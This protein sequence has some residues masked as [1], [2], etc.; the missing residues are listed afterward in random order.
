MPFSFKISSLFALN[1]WELFT[2]LMVLVSP[3]AVWILVP[4]TV[5]VL[6]V[7][8]VVVVVALR[9]RR[10]VRRVGVLRWGKVARVTNADEI[11]RG[12][13]FSG[14]TYQN[15]RLRQATGW[16]TTTRWYSGPG[17][18]ST[19]NYS[20]DDSDGTLTLRGLP[21][22]NGVILADPRKPNRAYCVSSFPFSVKPDANGEYVDHGL[23]PWAWLGIGLTVTVYAA[24]IA[25][26]WYAVDGLWLDLPG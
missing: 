15:I 17:S 16:D 18:K 26:A 8:L 9:A 2:I 22:A 3:I 6:F 10:Y 19:I 1:V 14:T 13:Y 20:V 5:P 25:G 7:V 4:W 21:Y 24:L 12:T 11:S 23:S